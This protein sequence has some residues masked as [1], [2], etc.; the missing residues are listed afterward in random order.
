[1][2]K[3]LALIF[4]AFIAASAPAHA[5]QVDEMMLEGGPIASHHFQSGDNNFRQRHELAIAKVFTHDYGNWALYFLNPNSV[6]KTSVGVGYV[7]R[8]W[9]VPVSGP[10]SLEFSG[11]LGLVTGYQSYP[12]PLLAGEARL[13]L[14]HSGGWD[15]GFTA[16]ALPYITDDDRDGKTKFGIVATTPFLSVRYKFR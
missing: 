1:M 6:R 9:V 7:T 14:F 10:V 15:A 2:K 5:G 12:V 3:L 8:P 11:G 16:A 13:V 4:A